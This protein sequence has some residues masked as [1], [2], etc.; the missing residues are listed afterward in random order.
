MLEALRVAPVRPPVEL[1]VSR[2]EETGLQGVKNL[3]FSRL[4]AKRGFLMDNDTLDTI[5]IGG[6]TYFAI[7]VTVTGRAAHAGMEPEKGINAIQAAA[8]A[9]GRAPAGTPR[10]RDH[11]QRRG[12][13]GRAHP[14]RRA[15]LCTFWPSAA[16]R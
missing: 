10:R 2:Q 7:D 15:R 13:P 12:H 3:D 11:R 9:I 16:A 5:V 6:P 8:R 4:T 1:A 14:Q